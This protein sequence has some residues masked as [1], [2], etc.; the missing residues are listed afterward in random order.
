MT[1]EFAS[2]SALDRRTLL[3]GAGLAGGALGL[4]AWLPAWARPVSAGIA[5]PLPQL[6]GEAITLRVAHET[7][8]VDGRPAK[9]IAMNGTVPAPLLRLRE[10][11]TVRIAVE[12]ALDE[13]TSVHWHGLLVPFQMDGVPGVSFP[14]IKP[15]STFTYEFALEQSGTYWYHSHSGLQEAMGHYG[16]IVIDPKGVDPIAYDREH[17]VVL[18][19]HSFIHPHKLFTKLK[20]ES[21]YFNRQKQ[22]LAGLA[23]GKDQSHAERLEWARMRM[24]P[25]DILDVTGSV[26]TYVTNGHG[27]RDN[28]TA[29]FNPGERVRLRF[30]N[31]SAMTIFNVRIPGLR[32]TVVAADG[33]PVRPISVDE[34]QMTI[35]ET[36]DVIVTP[37]DDRA[38]SIIGEAADRSGLARATLAPRPGMV[39]PVPAL[40]ERPL[41]TMKD[42]G[43]GGMGDEAA[44]SA[45]SSA[46]ANQGGAHG[47]HEMAGMNMPH[48]SGST[49]HGG[50]THGEAARH[51]MAMR[52]GA[53]AP[54]VKLGPGVQSIAPM[55][56]DR[57][58]EPGVGLENVGHKVLVYRDLVA[59][60]RNPDTRG[61]AREI[62][63]HLTGNM[64]RYMWSMDGQTLSEA[65]TPIPLRTGERVRVTLVNDTMMSHPIHLHG[66]FFE[67]VT[68]HGA[69]SPRKHTVNVA[70]GG[71]VSFDVTGIHGDWAFHCHMFF[72]MHAGMMRVVQVRDSGDLA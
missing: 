52:D 32:M 46:A 31:A 62:E 40:R 56:V 48:S 30:I 58:G 11:Q 35:A 71:K 3:R 65:R 17:V 54:Q 66:H 43:M 1:V 29:L 25:T 18:S 33:L 5:R 34:F 37:G 55:P 15:R 16:P 67:L 6:S 51:A 14:G 24:D 4:S 70:P 20:Q 47:G 7:I 57:T 41:L 19:D 36:Y 21:G 12:N 60:E 23:A 64:E 38:Y 72:H 26:Y 13:E 8:T 9:A 28:W 68:G 69:H 50:T 39:A 10:G 2:P 49:E 63:V 42:M 22:T 59:L 53:N 45:S 27:P 61:P 44:T